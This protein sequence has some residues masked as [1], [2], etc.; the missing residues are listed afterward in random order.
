MHQICSHG[1][2]T[3][4]F[5]ATNLPNHTVGG[6]GKPSLEYN[7]HDACPVKYKAHLELH[8]HVPESNVID[9]ERKRVHKCE[10]EEGVGYP[11]VEDLELL[12]GNAREERDPVRLGCRRT[13]QKSVN[14]CIWTNAG[15]C[16]RVGGPTKQRACMPR[17]S[18]P[19]LFPT[20][21]N[22]QSQDSASSMVGESDPCLRSPARQSR[23][24][25]YM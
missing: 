6:K 14:T 12:V 25:R 7:G 11:S 24:L 22:Y 16:D 13:G 2:Y 9:D 15:S 1:W 17:P 23:C 8:D 5:C 18:I 20:G 10:E 4:I 21:E 19:I 3:Y